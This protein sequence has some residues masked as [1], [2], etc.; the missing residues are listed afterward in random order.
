MQATAVNTL[1]SSELVLLGDS[2]DRLLA[3]RPPARKGAGG[4]DVADPAAWTELT[5]LGIA[6]LLFAEDDGGLGLGGPE[7]SVVMQ[8]LGRRLST[9]PFLSSAILAGGILRHLASPALRATLAP[10]IVSG[11][12]RGALAYAELGSRYGATWAETR[13]RASDEGF[14]IDGEKTTVIDA[15]GADYLF[16]TARIDDAA[17]IGVFLVPGAAPGLTITPYTTIDGRAAAS[18]RFDGVTVSRDAQVGAAADTSA[19]LERVLDEARLAL[20][21]ESVGAI[22]ELNRQ[23]V[24][25]CRTRIAFGQ[26]LAKQQVL[27]HR[28]VDMHVAAEYASAIVDAAAAALAGDAQ[29]RAQTIAAAAAVVARE[30]DFVAKAAVQLHGA[31]GTTEE[32]PIGRYFKRILANDRLLGGYDEN[33]IRYRELLRAGRRAPL[34]AA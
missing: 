23:T 21:A 20:A 4:F 7:L 5:Q 24:E 1:S 11:E 17:G 30:G 16:V 19:A 33:A 25:Y 31:I 9:E 14:A 3:D 32:L 10:D 12:K 13:A 27:Q 22:E 2:V 15:D 26:P 29:R 34:H 28:L 8:A 18:L 6:G